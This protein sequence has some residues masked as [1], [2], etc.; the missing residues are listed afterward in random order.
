MAFRTK[1]KPLTTLTATGLRHKFYNDA[2]VLQSDSAVADQTVTARS[3]Y[4]TYQTGS[5]SGRHKVCV[6]NRTAWDYGDRSC[7]PQTLDLIAPGYHVTSA[8]HQY[9]TG[10]T[11]IIATRDAL[12]A[13]TGGGTP[14]SFQ[15][16]GRAAY[17]RLKPDLTTMSIPNFIYEL[18]DFRSLLTFWRGNNRLAKLKKM[19][20]TSDDRINTYASSHLQYGF[21]VAPFLSDVSKLVGTLKE[22]EGE[23]EAWNKRSGELIQKSAVIYDETQPASGDYS[24]PFGR[25]YWTGKRSYKAEVFFCWKILP[26]PNISSTLTRVRYYLDKFG[27]E[28][29]PKVLWDTIP[30]SFLIDQFLGVGNFLNSMKFD[31]LKVPVLLVDSFVQVKEKIEY[32]HYY[33]RDSGAYTVT[34]KTPE[35]NYTN[36]FFRRMTLPTGPVFLQGTGFKLPSAGAAL[37]DVSLAVALATGKRAQKRSRRAVKARPFLYFP[38]DL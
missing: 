24:A 32:T 2:G 22:M 16:E 33:L 9:P 7:S 14:V 19:V 26:F 4:I 17:L 13:A 31:T 36:E 27:F 29:N 23:L 28:L 18:K 3:S 30:F 10:S 38:S 37:L 15:T 1:E 25:I 21:G 12:I 34:V 5:R 35:V 6:H 8:Y 20:S 11:N